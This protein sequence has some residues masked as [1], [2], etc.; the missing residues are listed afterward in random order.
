[1]NTPPISQQALA[2]KSF[3]NSSES[4]FTNPLLNAQPYIP[5]QFESPSKDTQ[6]MT[7]L[8]Y[9]LAISFARNRLNPDQEDK[10]VKEVDDMMAADGCSSRTTKVKKKQLKVI[11]SFEGKEQFKNAR[12]TFSNQRQFL[13]PGVFIDKQESAKLK[14]KR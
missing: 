14:D 2:F 6:P 4:A 9:Q 1:M 3:G 12:N 13:D 10:Q 8:P 11:Y 7:N 5:G